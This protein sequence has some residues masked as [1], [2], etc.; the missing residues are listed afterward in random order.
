MS[1]C[2]ILLHGCPNVSCGGPSAQTSGPCVPSKGTCSGLRAQAP[3]GTAVGHLS[4]LTT[5]NGADG[6]IRTDDP[7][8]TNQ[9]AIQFQRAIL[10]FRVFQG[11][12][13]STVLSMGVATLVATEN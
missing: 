11:R 8:F 12:P 5:K 1:T 13:L 6:R 9:T 7:L 3:N 2:R 4:R 10:A